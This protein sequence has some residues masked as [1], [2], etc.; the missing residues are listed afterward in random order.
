MTPFLPG[1]EEPECERIVRSPHAGRVVQAWKVQAVCESLIEPKRLR[2][3]HPAEIAAF[4]REYV[5]RYPG[6][7]GEQEH[8]AVFCLDRRNFMRGWE[9]VSTG[10]MTAALVH[11]REVYR[12]AIVAGS[13]VIVCAHN[14]P[15]GDPAPSSAD[16]QITRQLVAAGRAVE[17]TLMDHVVVGVP[18][19]DP[20]NRGYYSF[21]EAGLL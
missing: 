12:A 13:V 17:I 18:A 7:S 10:S 20:A 11:P 6:Y 2:M 16:L 14:H 9:L 1:L 21:R 15:S 8:F 4:W 3:E 5:T 19:R